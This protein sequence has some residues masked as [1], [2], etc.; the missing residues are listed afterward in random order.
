MSAQVDLPPL[1]TKYAYLWPLLTPPDDYAS[2]AAMY[3]Q[4]I[5]AFAPHAATLLEAG[6]GAGNHAF[7]LKNG[8]QTTLTDAS[9]AM[10]KV[11]R[12]AN[13]DCEHLL[14]DM[15]SMRLGREFDT[16]FIQDALA[17]LPT[18][19]DLKRAILTAYRHCKPGGVLL[20]AP[21]HVRETFIPTSGCGGSDQGST[22]AR[23]LEWVHSP[24]RQ[25]Y[26][27]DFVVMLKEGRKPVK[28]L[29]DQHRASL[30][31]RD[32]WL[33]ALSSAG[34]EPHPILFSDYDPDLPATYEGFVGVRPT[35]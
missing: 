14:E 16:V 18:Y 3:G 35:L 33:E 10:L 21:D 31:S 11:S 24:A 8:F 30:F 22:S 34:F 29:R 15:R 2:D 17:Y 6:S 20:L 19:R 23:Y 12:Q 9:E 4:V 26:S 25:S 13:P 1:Y 28:V 32:Q 7:H 5:K 27:V